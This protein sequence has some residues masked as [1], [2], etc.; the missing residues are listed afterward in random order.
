MQRVVDSFCILT[1]Y[2]KEAKVSAVSGRTVFVCI[3]QGLVSVFRQEASW[4]NL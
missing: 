2:E 3:V 1:A 4:Q